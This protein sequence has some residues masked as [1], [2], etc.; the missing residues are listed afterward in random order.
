[1]PLDPTSGPGGGGGSFN[2]GTITQPLT[3][4][5][6]GGPA[7]QRAFHVIL[8]ADFDFSV[9]AFTFE[10]DQ[11]STPLL[12]FTTNGDVSTG[13]NGLQ[14]GG[15]SILTGTGLI[16]TAGDTSAVAAKDHNQ[17]IAGEVS[18]V[19][20]VATY[21]N[22]APAD[23]DLSPGTCSLWLDHTD[24][25][26]NTKLMLKGKSADGTVKTASIVLA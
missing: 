9:E 15:G 22:A 26:G 23:S 2:G 14:T 7:D 25:V 8:P 1:M 21:L 20:G 13:G 6:S 18:A 10:V 11:Q 12:A 24:G 5:L 3:I 16:S 19:L 4:D 17:A